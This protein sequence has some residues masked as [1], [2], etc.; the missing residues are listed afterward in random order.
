[1]KRRFFLCAL[2][3]L[4]AVAWTETPV[5]PADLF[6]AA[7][8]NLAEVYAPK[9]GTEAQTFSTTLKI[10]KAPMKELAGRSATL[11]YE[12]PDKLVLSANVQDQRYSLGRRGDEVW[13]HVPGK[14]WGVIGRTD[15]P[16]FSRDP[17][18][19]D[20]ASVP[21]FTFPQ[22]AKLAL[23]PTLAP[24]KNRLA[25]RCLERPAAS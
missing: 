6:T 11:A 20:P 2:L 16:K 8:E 7:V 14:N 22:R 17:A 9:P 19:V 24:S 1:M 25:K 21:L 13:F 10:V 12:A 3:V 15:V 4:P 23:L 5:S 18:S